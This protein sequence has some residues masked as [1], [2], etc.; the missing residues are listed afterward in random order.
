MTDWVDAVFFD[1]GQTLIYV[2]PSVGSVY[3]EVARLHGVNADPQKLQD[4]FRA[5][6]RRAAEMRPKEP[7]FAANFTSDEAERAWWRDMV[8]KVF[9]VHPG[10]ET[11][12]KRFDAFFDQVFHHF[13]K[14]EAWRV[15]EDVTPTLDRLSRAGLRCAVVSNWDSR[16]PILL[17]R[18]GLLRYFVCV[19]TSAEIGCAKP[20]PRI[21]EAAVAR[22]NAA[23]ERTVHIGDSIE[24]DVAGALGAGLRPMLIDRE[25]R[26]TGE[27]PRLATLM[28]LP[29]EL[30]LE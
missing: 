4:A 14:P 24:D 13:A 3:S 23:P 7:P 16:L 11:F 30:G 1:A 8:A 2:Y 28:D 26:Y 27:H 20:D 15:Y 12:G 5:E 10:L 9:A 17:E 22:L 25:A 21:F 29:S 18:L 6:W 19:V